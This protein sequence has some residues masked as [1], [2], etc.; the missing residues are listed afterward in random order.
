MNAMRAETP[1][2]NNRRANFVAVEPQP[3]RAPAGPVAGIRIR[4]LARVKEKRGLIARAMTSCA[5]AVVFLAGSVSLWAQTNA[6]MTADL[7]RQPLS[8]VEAVELALR[9]NGTLLQA[10]ADISA[11][12]GRG[13]QS[14]SVG[15]PRVQ[16]S[17][18]YKIQDKGAIETFAGFPGSGNQNWSASAQVVQP[19]YEGG[20]IKSGSRSDQFLREQ[21][22]ARYASVRL[23][24]IANVLV[25]YDDVLLASEQILVQEASVTLLERELSD[26]QKR[27]DAGTATRFNVL[28]A[29]VAVANAKPRLIKARN[30]FR[31]SKNNLVNLLGYD[32]PVAMQDDIPLVLADRLRS[33]PVGFGLDAALARALDRR[34]ELEALRQDIALRQEDITTSKAGRRP[35]VQAFAG[36]G[37]R[38]SSFNNDLGDVVEG[39]FV[40]ARLS[41]DLWDGALTKG[42]VVEA[43]ARV[44]SAEEALRDTRRQIGLEV[45]TA[46][47]TVNDAREVLQSQEKTVEQ[48]EEAL[49]LARSR[50][51]AGTGTQLEI[52]DAETALTEARN[53][54]TVALRDYSVA[55]IRLER[56]AAYL[57]P[58]TA[59]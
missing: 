41:W 35:A 37:A 55:K 14:R 15:Q 57:D 56:A 21:A 42:R 23:D 50:S 12:G 10:K 17:S 39:W 48:A 43:T 36:Y 45:R 5:A 40:G 30:A 53:T 54:R 7:F 47:S 33:E 52:L 6:S 38:N 8:R 26:N 49:R 29:E 44:E 22:G 20:R 19:L 1:Q 58:S 27:F 11:A 32:L 25:A 28:R 34:P 46:W 16:I 2:P 31:T 18:E 59:P 51:E 4:C 24:T 9:Q 13:Q 3:V